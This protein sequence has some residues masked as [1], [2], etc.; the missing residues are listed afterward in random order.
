[1]A[2]VTQ[3]RAKE[4]D[5]ILPAE[6]EVVEASQA[7]QKAMTL[8]GP[9]FAQQ[10]VEQIAGRFPSHPGTRY[11]QAT[12][13][14]EDGRIGQALA[15]FRELMERYPNAPRLRSNLLFACRAIGNTTLLR[16]TLKTVAETGTIPGVESQIDWIYPHPRCVC[17]YADAIR[18]SL[19]ARRQA[20]NLLRS[21][22]KTQWTSA[23][24]WHVLADLRAD[25]HEMGSALLAYSVASFLA[26]HNEHYARAYVDALVQN[27]RIEE[28]LEWLQDRVEQL[29]G[30]LQ[31]VSTW[32]TW[33]SVL[34]DRGFP[35]RAILGC[36]S[37]LERHGTATAFAVPF[38]AR[39]GWWEQAEAQLAALARSEVKAAFHEA[40]VA[41]H[42]MRGQPDKALGHAESWV[43]EAPRSIDAR[44]ALLAALSTL[45]G[46]EIAAMRA[47]EWMLDHPANEDFEQAFC[48]YADNRLYWRKIRVL[49]KRVKRNREDGWAWRELVFSALTVFEKGDERRRNRLRPKIDAHFVEVDR[50]DPNDATTIR[51]HGLW[52]EDRQEWR[53]AVDCYLEAIRCQPDHFYA[54]RRAWEC[55]ARFPELERRDVWAKIE[56]LYLGSSHHLP[57]PLEMMRLLAA[58]FGVRHTETIV[59]RWRLQRPDDPNVLEA[60]V[61]LLLDRGHGHSDAL[62]ALDLL[63]GAVDRFP[64]HSGLAFRWPEPTVPLTTIREQIESSRSWCD[65]GRTTTRR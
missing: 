3:E 9:S 32:V 16:Q 55:S 52:K 2:V 23:F 27:R 49:R 61:D 17:E 11:L 65:V 1:M 63:G 18:M 36:E 31:G 28:G 59:A 40:S 7:H 46:R 54:Y 35:E 38:L 6:A 42:R 30:S 14:M 43:V 41:Y 20:E 8:Y 48:Q 51:A 10:V 24:A 15:G 21:V 5:E 64:Y 56:E 13:D 33:I 45:Q 29:G 57:N 22:L 26:A 4:L 47:Y 62:R 39:M 44:Y 37:A 25:Q 53:G 50:V 34:E 19:G 12:Q 60:A 58:R